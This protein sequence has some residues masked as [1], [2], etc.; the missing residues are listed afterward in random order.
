M[1]IPV[2]KNWSAHQPQVWADT[3]AKEEFDALMAIIEKL[4]A[5]VAG[6]KARVAMLERGQAARPIG[7]PG[8][9]DAQGRWVPR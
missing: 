4:S 5:E 2:T 8:A 6:L 7:R 9:I 1:R 3:V